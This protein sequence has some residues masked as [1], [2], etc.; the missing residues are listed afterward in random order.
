M[1]SIRSRG[2]ANTWPGFVDALANMLVVLIVVLLLFFVF[3]LYLGDTL[4][5]RD[6]EIVALKSELQELSEILSLETSEKERFEKELADVRSL[7]SQSQESERELSLLL[8][9]ERKQR[10]QEKE[11]LALERELERENF[12]A[13]LADLEARNTALEGS[14]SQ[15]EQ[16]LVEKDQEILSIQNAVTE[17]KEQIALLN[18]ILAAS[19]EKDRKSQ[20]TIKALGERLNTA[21]AGKVQ[22]L[23]EYRSDFFGRLKKVLANNKNIQVVGDRFIFSSEVLF[24]VGSAELQENGKAELATLAPSLIEISRLIPRDINWILQVEGHTDDVP[25]ETP[26][27]SSNWELS[28][29]RAV[30]VARFLINEGL[31]PSRLSVAGFAEYQPVADIATSQN[32]DTARKQNR[33]IE[34]RLTQH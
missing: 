6:R 11:Q 15:S 5:G 12:S 19:E 7:L 18:Q 3:Q 1:R 31:P 8:D 16:T 26:L 33:R 29:A 4:S 32:I 22:D 9:E 17:L 25:I 20:A 10:Q 24:D 30:S 27:F 34:L 28:S 13:T 14:L 21:L 2:G 23:A